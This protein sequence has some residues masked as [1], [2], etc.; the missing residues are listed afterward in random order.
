MV[1]L[2]CCPF[3]GSKAKIHVDEYCYGINGYYIEC[4][5]K[6]CEA[7]IFAYPKEKAL[8]IWNNRILWGKER[9]INE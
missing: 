8:L 5:N 2:K 6:D 7:N 1:E 3:C 9:F 4:I